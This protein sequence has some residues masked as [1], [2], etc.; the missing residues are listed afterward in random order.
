MDDQ[1]PQVFPLLR[2]HEFAKQNGMS[3]EAE[4]IREMDIEW[5]HP[6]GAVAGVKFFP[7]Q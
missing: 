7:K 3:E 4:T 1:E 5:E 6:S 2:A